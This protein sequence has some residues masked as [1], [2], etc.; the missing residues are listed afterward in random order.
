MTG[1]IPPAAVPTRISAHPS[2]L[3]AQDATLQG[4]ITLGQGCIVHPKATI[5]APNG[6]SVVIGDN[7][8]FEELSVVRYTGTEE[9]RI[10]GD[11]EFLVGCR[12]L[13][14]F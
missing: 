1:I 4:A 12:E 6:G 7:C 10:G 14:S 2:V 11:N 3:I 8:S 5:S 9:M 13:V